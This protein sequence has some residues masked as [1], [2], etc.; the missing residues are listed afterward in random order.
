MVLL[1]YTNSMLTKLRRLYEDTNLYHYTL[2]LA[3][4]L[5]VY[6]YRLRSYAPSLLPEEVSQLAASRAPLVSGE[7]LS[8]PPYN[9]VQRTATYLFG[10]DS[11]YAVR[12]CAFFYIVKK[13][14]R[15]KY[16][17]FGALLFGFST[18][19]LH[20]ARTAEP[21]IYLM[22]L[23]LSIG[24]LAIKVYES[25]NTNLLILLTVMSL[26]PLYTP[27]GWLVVAFSAPGI[28]YLIRRSVI[29]LRS[30]T[31][32]AYLILVVAALAPLLYTLIHT[33]LSPS[34]LCNCAS[35]SVDN[36]TTAATALVL[37]YEAPQS[38][39][40]GEFA[41]VGLVGSIL[42]TLGLIR[43]SLDWRSKRAA[44]FVVS[45]TLGLILAGT[46][47]SRVGLAVLVPAIYLLVSYGY[48]VLSRRWENTFPTNPAARSFGSLVLGFLLLLILNY[49]M[50][51]YFVVWT[52]RP[53][54]LQY[55][56]TTP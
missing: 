11:L 19:M 23:G 43:L 55:F 37:T 39:W 34:V 17:Y 52:Q 51:R 33:D 3:L 42:A 47:S 8:F 31:T 44:L 7:F 22:A 32:L 30:K 50:Q 48:Q 53:E 25:R 41:I 10:A 14:S 24:A 28:F 2:F 18:F 9:F 13:L 27:G 29:N 38:L 35:F 1:L 16:A 15:E 21:T 12:V 45:T 5:A 6:G 46:T 54:T 20:A 4:F 40:A 56:E 49:Q 36:V 26:L